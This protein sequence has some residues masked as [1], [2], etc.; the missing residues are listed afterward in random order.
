MQLY[1]FV[2][3]LNKYYPQGKKNIQMSDVVRSSF[4]WMQSL[5]SFHSSG[6]NSQT[7]LSFYETSA[8]TKMSLIMQVQ[9]WSLPNRREEGSSEESVTPDG[10]NAAEKGGE[11]RL[12]RTKDKRDIIL[13][14]FSHHVCRLDSRK[15]ITKRYG[16]MI[17]DG[18]P[19]RFLLLRFW[20]WRNTHTAVIL[21]F[22]HYGGVVAW[23][24]FFK[25]TRNKE[26][27]ESSLVQRYC[28][29]ISQSHII[30]SHGTVSTLKMQQ[31]HVGVLG[32]TAREN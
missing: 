14:T 32:V 15:W 30:I 18:P 17:Y 28:Y 22:A 31:A 13:V 5:C 10:A 4:F 12:I 25:S 11:G 24:N 8:L 3:K 20:L 29:S 19:P 1:V 6:S 27:N 23:R 2:G 9:A 26:N 21:W 7:H 16:L